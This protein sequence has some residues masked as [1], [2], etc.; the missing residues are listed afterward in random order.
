MVI[1][2]KSGVSGAGRTPTDRVHYSHAT[3]N[4]SPYNVYAHRHAPEIEQELGVE[5]TFT[6]HLV[7]VDRGLLATCYARLAD[8]AEHP[9]DLLAAIAT[10][11]PATPSWRWWTLRRGCAPVI[12][13]LVFVLLFGRGLVGPWLAAHDIKIIFAVPGIVL[14]T[15]FVTFPFVAR[16]LIPLMQ[17]QGTEEEQAALTLGAGGWQCSSA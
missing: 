6:A 5:V 1:D 15:T 12:S 8:G 16:E 17:A 3:D 10:S 9:D 7:P 13:G 14:A 2:A 4:V 11:T